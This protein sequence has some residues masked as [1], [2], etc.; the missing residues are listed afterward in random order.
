VSPSSLDDELKAGGIQIR[1]SL[2]TKIIELRSDS[3]RVPC[4]VVGFAEKQRC[5][6][7]DATRSRVIVQHVDTG[8]QKDVMEPE[9]D[10]A[11]G[12]S[13]SICDKWC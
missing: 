5:E 11:G 2:Q 10:E 6:L 8:R 3:G 7:F 1:T 12:K 9:G 4:H 13:P